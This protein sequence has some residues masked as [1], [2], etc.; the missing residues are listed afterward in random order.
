M[1]LFYLLTVISICAYV[2]VGCAL[3]VAF[4]CEWAYKLEVKFHGV[5]KAVQNLHEDA[6]TV[7]R[8]LA[9]ALILHALVLLVFG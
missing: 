3:F 9:V 5:D 7:Y 8:L 1:I 4:T 6:K 2:I